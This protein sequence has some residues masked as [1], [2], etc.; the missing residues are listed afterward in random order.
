MILETT[1]KCGELYICPTPIG[2]LED[3]TLR[4]MRILKEADI[5]AA[6]DTR[7]TQKLLNHFGINTPLVS[8]HEHNKHE[9]TTELTEKL[10]SGKNIALVSD[11][12]MPGI[13]DP[14]YDFIK[15]ALEK[16]VRVIP[17][18]GANAA[19]TALVGSGFSTSLFTFVGFLPKTSKKRRE[20]LISLKN[21]DYT[22]IFY[23]SPHRLINTLDEMI[24]ILGDRQAAAARELTKK[25]EEFVRGSL[26]E[27]RRHFTENAPRG[28]ITLV[29]DAPS[30]NEEA[31]FK[32][33]YDDAAL[34]K[35]VD[36]M[37]LSG[38]NKKDAIKTIASNLG[39]SKRRVYQA[40]INK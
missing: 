28:E 18:P 13:S 35:I 25:F 15:L 40:V 33:N 5:I 20:M 24:N 9:K 16:G 31:V 8:Y 2:N 11:A 30:K 17:L 19:I 26:T 29:V 1:V 3:M 32:E 12:G 37:V 36:E 7:H 10:L 4:A 21:H 23:E 34:V 27:I 38:A 22:L 6:E 14:G 39:L